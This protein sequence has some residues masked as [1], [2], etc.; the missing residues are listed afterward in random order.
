MYQCTEGQAIFKTAEN[1][2][3]MQTNMHTLGRKKLKL[4]RQPCIYK[5]DIDQTQSAWL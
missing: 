4:L 1:K 2:C 5:V 3:K